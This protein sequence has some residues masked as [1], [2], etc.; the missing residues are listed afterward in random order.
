MDLAGDVLAS[1]TVKYLRLD[2]D[3]IAEGAETHEELCYLDED[4]V[5]EIS[6]DG[7]IYITR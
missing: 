3:Q 1:G 7:R 4:G 2:V 5:R 6:F